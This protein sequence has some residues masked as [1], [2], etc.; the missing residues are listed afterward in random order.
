MVWRYG[1]RIKVA[2]D[3]AF[4]DVRKPKTAKRGVYVLDVEEIARLRAALEVTS[5]RLVVELA[6]TTGLRS[7]EIRGLRWESNRSRGQAPVC[8][9]GPVT[10][11]RR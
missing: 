11:A 3:N 7:G 8:G 4:A 9:A 10:A 2:T 5:D 6:I 1:R